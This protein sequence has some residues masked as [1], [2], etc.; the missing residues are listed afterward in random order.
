MSRH[1]SIA[2]GLLLLLVSK[3]G[4]AADPHYRLTDV[5]DLTS[6]RT[7]GVTFVA[8]IGEKGEIVGQSFNNQFRARAFLWQAGRMTD[9]GDFGNINGQLPILSAFAINKRLEIVGS[10]MGGSSPNPSRAFRWYRSSIADLGTLRGMGTDTFATGINEHS[11]IVGAGYRAPGDLRALRWVRGVPTELGTAADGRVA[12]QAF[13]I[14]S[15]G[16]IVGYLSPGGTS[17]FAHAFIWRKGKFTDLGTLPG[18]NLSFANA[19]NEH[20]QV[21]GQSLNTAAPGTS[22]AFL[23]EEGT[24]LDLGKVASSHKSSEARA[25]NRNS[26]IVGL[27]GTGSS[28]LAWVWRD[29][30]TRDLNTLV[31]T[32]DPNRRYV[33]LTKAVAINDKG[34]IAAQGVDSRRGSNVVR[35][36]LLTP[37]K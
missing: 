22:R 1:I 24:L 2:A 6:T 17:R 16:D 28:T 11:D 26:V 5:G 32:D 18:T 36:Y 27:S 3:F 29:G 9:L 30:T 37:V 10:V 21:V 8:A 7:N 31:A 19:L 20:A 25:I 35:G 12:V 14:N 15:H 34:Q 4:F 33:R 23:W 13:G